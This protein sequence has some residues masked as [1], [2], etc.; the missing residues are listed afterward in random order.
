MFTRQLHIHHITLVYSMHQ[1]DIFIDIV[2]IALYSTYNYIKGCGTNAAFGPSSDLPRKSFH[3]LPHVGSTG[4]L[5]K[6]WLK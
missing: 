3:Q 4:R 6:G 1:S 5:K 2:F